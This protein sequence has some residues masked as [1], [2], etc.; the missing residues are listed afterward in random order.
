M[1]QF[2]ATAAT[3]TIDT[4]IVL[5]SATRIGFDVTVL[6]SALPAFTTTERV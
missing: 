4:L 1:V 2:E 5:A 3:L 6:L